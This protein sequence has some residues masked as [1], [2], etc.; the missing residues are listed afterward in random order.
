MR[1]SLVSQLWPHHLISEWGINPSK[2]R[3]IQADATTLEALL[4]GSLK[5]AGHQSCPERPLPLLEVQRTS[6]SL[7]QIPGNSLSPANFSMVGPG[8]CLG[9][10]NSTCHWLLAWISSRFSW[11]ISSSTPTYVPSCLKS[12]PRNSAGPTTS[13]ERAWKLLCHFTA[14]RKV[15]KLL[16]WPYSRGIWF[17]CF[18]EDTKSLPWSLSRCSMKPIRS[19]EL[20]D[21]CHQ[22]VFVAHRGFSGIYPEHPWISRADQLHFYI[23]AGWELYCQHILQIQGETSSCPEELLCRLV[24]THGAVVDP[25]WQARYEPRARLGQDVRP[26]FRCNFNAVILLVLI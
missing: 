13:R 24:L 12:E 11:W 10:S 25:G 4:V 6:I 20:W 9:I 8:G 1:G 26:N 14:D 7:G 16:P 23:S 5:E 15:G 18:S 17:K 21:S 3:P 2:N 19:D 22:E